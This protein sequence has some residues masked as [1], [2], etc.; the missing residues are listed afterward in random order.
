MMKG[1]MNSTNIW[2][3]VIEDLNYKQFREG[4]VGLTI[5]V[6]DLFSIS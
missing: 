5:M 4:Y 6:I 3:E 1:T 2:Q